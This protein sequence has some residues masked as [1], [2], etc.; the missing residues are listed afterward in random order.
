ME[1][2]AFQVYGILL[3]QGLRKAPG[4]V[5]KA[6]LAAAVGISDVMV[7]QVMIGLL[8]AGLVISNKGRYQGG[9]SLAN[10][11]HRA[12]VAE[13]VKAMPWSVRAS[14]DERFIEVREKVKAKLEGV[15]G[16][17]RVDDL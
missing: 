2:S 1:L 16:L 17:M 11:R 14:K 9:Y 13:V 4:R 3:L 10:R 8:G 7:Q 12:T 5:R 15:M 6:D